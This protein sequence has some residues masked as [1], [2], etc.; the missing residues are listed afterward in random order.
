MHYK[1]IRRGH[2]KRDLHP[3]TRSWLYKLRQQ[4]MVLETRL[5]KT[6][7]DAEKEGLC[8]ALIMPTAGR[9][10]PYKSTPPTEGHVCC[11]RV[12]MRGYCTR[13]FLTHV[14]YLR[15]RSHGRSGKGISCRPFN[16]SEFPYARLSEKQV[17]LMTDLEL[18]PLRTPLL[19]CIEALNT[20]DPQNPVAAVAIKPK[21]C[22]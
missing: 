13:H 16:P 5:A 9:D 15:D 7:S 4:E 12:F 11:D 19:K 18:L 17:D 21:K 10:T 6:L 1:K 3:M 22:P 8:V 14:L 20:A 2:L